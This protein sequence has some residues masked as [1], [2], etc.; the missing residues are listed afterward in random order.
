MALAVPGANAFIGTPVRRTFVNPNT[1][2]VEFRNRAASVRAALDVSM[3]RPRIVSCAFEV[4]KLV[5]AEAVFA[6]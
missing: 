2:L 3:S 1:P 6:Y 5:F 4:R